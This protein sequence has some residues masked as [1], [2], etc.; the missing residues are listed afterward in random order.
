MLR[1]ATWMTAG[2]SSPAILNMLGSISNSPC[3]AVKVVASAPFLQCAVQ[4]ARSTGLRLHL[5]NFGYLAPEVGPPRCCPV[6]GVLAHCRGGGDRVDGD[7][8]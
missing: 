7:H 5:D 8:I 1:A 6:V 2:I 3:E 4:G